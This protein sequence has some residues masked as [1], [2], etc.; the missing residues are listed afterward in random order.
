[1]EQVEFSNI[2]ILNKTDLVNKEQQQDI[3]ERINIT[4]R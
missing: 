4:P 2:V 1:M 3:L